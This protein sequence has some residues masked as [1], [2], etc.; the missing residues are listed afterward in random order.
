MARNI[1]VTITSEQDQIRN[2]VPDWRIDFAVSWIDKNGEPQQVETS[3]YFLLLLN[4]LRNEN[5]QAG[6]RLMQNVAYRIA[7]AKH[8]IDNVEDIA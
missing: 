6:K 5:P 4:W 7:R 8:G 2:N 3:E 1:N